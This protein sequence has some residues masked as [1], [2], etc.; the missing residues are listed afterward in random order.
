MSITRGLSTTRS[1][2]LP[3]PA[4]TRLVTDPSE[5]HVEEAA[6]LVES[7]YWNEGVPRERLVRAMLGSTVVVVALDAEGS[8]V[9]TARALSDGARSAWL[10]DVCVGRAWR[11]KGVGKA[12]VKAVLEHP[13]VKDADRVRLN[14]RD[15]QRLYA[16]LG[17]VETLKERR[18]YP[19]VE[20][21]RR[22]R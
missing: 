1:S 19:S 17:F 20:M 9:A 6:A 3:G 8:V 22:R 14:T 4:G 16:E 7:E 5:A 2:W 13:G 21:V 10:G 15:A 18:P 11:G 12:V